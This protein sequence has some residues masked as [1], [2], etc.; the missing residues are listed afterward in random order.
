MS[1]FEPSRIPAWLAPVCEERSVS[2]SRKR[3]EPSASQRAIVGAFPSRIARWRTGLREP[4]DL[5]EEDP[6]HVGLHTLA[7]TAR[8]ALDDADRVRVVVVRAGDDLERGRDR[9]DHE[10]RDQSPPKPSTT[11]APSVSA[12]AA[13]RSTASRTSTSRNDVATVYGRWIA[14]TSGARTAFRAAM[15]SAASSA[16]QK[17]PTSNPGADRGGE[18]DAGGADDAATAGAER[19]ATAVERPCVAE[20]PHARSAS[21]R[22]TLLS[23]S[24]RRHGASDYDH[25]GE[26]ASKRL[27]DELDRSYAEAQERMADP[28]VYNDRIQGAA[29]R[30]PAEGARG[31]AS[32]RRASGGRR[33]ADL[34]DARADPELAGMASELEPRSLGSRRSSSSRSSRRTR[35]TRRT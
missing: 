19:G 32:A 28:A 18:E 27:V 14:A 1:S 30:P 33:R 4:V 5:E 12:S 20:A 25:P 23:A 16:A 6:G 2:H 9:R 29:R 22:A 24:S 3:C 17:P 13:S 15:T 35:P 7:R 11:M 21:R 34:D 26:H 8:D 10:R 31:P